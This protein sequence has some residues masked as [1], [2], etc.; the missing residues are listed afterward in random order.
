MSTYH[1]VC[2]IQS[3][4]RQVSTRCLCERLV[5][6]PGI[7]NTKN[8]GSWKATWIRLLK[9]SRVKGP[10][11]GV[12]PVT[13]AHFSITWWPVFLDDMILTSARV[14]VSTMAQAAYKSFF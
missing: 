8:L 2:V 6:S 11:I 9:F 1:R 4:D 14:S 7:C 10:E 5:V 12:A 13:V 3:N